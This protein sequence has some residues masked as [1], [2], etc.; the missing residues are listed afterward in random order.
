MPITK[1]D[2]INMLTAIAQG[3]CSTI[4]DIEHNGSRIRRKAMG[5]HSDLNDIF[6]HIPN[7]SVESSYIA[8]HCLDYMMHVIDRGCDGELQDGT[9]FC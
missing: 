9:D 6:R 4:M 1:H 8:S 5:A 2:A 3:C 7:G